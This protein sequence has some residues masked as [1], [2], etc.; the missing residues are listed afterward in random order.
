MKFKNIFLAGIFF[1]AIS[2]NL[3]AMYTPLQEAILSGSLTNVQ[4]R[5]SEK[6]ITAG[7]LQTALELVDRLMRSPHMPHDNII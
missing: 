7:E 6:S 4:T 1:T 3:F 2:G 5:L